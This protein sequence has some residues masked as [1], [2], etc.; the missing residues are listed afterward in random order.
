[1]SIVGQVDQYGPGNY[2]ADKKK[3]AVGITESGVQK[4]ALKAVELH[5]R[6]YVVMDA[7]F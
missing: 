4:D 2:E 5:R 3:R 7:R 6:D 1:M